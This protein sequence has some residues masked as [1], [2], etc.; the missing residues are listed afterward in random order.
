LRDQAA[1]DEERE[2]K[3]H[4]SIPVL[5][6]LYL[7]RDEARTQRDDERKQTDDALKERDEAREQRNN[8][9][10][11][12]DETLKE[13]SDA[14]SRTKDTL[15]ELNDLRRQ[16]EYGRLTYSIEAEDIFIE[17]SFEQIFGYGTEYKGFYVDIGAADP[18]NWSNTYSLHKRGWRGINIEPNPD[19]ALRFS[20]LRPDDINLTVAVGEEGTIATYARFE[21]PGLN[22]MFPR[23]LEIHKSNGERVID[24]TEIPFRSINSI[25]SEH[26]PVGSKVDFLNIDVEM[27]EFRILSSLDFSRWSPRV[28]AV[29]IQGGL[30]VDD[31]SRSDVATL[32]RSKGYTFISRL[33]HTSLFVFRPARSSNP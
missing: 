16:I 30:D 32:L 18:I 15:E 26:V 19:A 20:Q 31:I 22:T 13:L 27:M 8:V 17:R 3:F 5:R 2:M 1:D 25:L 29:E 11:Q 7:Q 28:V 4:H 21:N 14:R 24:V 6:R 33:W 9:L 10:K 12:R 23:A